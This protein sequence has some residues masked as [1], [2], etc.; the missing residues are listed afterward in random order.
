VKI[1]AIKLYRVDT[2]IIAEESFSTE[3]KTSSG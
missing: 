3:K 2:P 1:N